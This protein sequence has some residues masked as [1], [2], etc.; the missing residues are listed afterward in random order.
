[1]LP[2][3]VAA[4]EQWGGPTDEVRVV[5]TS[6]RIQ[7]TPTTIWQQIERVQPI[8]V[9]E[10]R[11]RGA[12]RSASHAPSKLPSSDGVGALGMLRL[13]VACCSSKP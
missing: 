3:V 6:I 5:A 1:M 7:A 2:F 10:Q 9:N 4:T 13:P 11:F 8:R 12:R